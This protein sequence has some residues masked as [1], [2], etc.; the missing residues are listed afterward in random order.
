MSKKKIARLESKWLEVELV[1]QRENA[2]KVIEIMD[3]YLRGDL[4][5][6][7]HVKILTAHEDPDDESSEEIREWHISGRVSSIEKLK[8]DLDFWKIKLKKLKK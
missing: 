6:N 5:E 2:L 3:N 7:C 1:V 8:E 4:S